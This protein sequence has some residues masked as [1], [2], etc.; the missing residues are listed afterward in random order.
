MS[1]KGVAG[2]VIIAFETEIS[3]AD[4]LVAKLSQKPMATAVSA[5]ATHM[6]AR[7]IE[8]PPLLW[9]KDEF[10]LVDQRHKTIVF[11]ETI[12]DLYSPARPQSGFLWPILWLEIKMMTDA[13]TSSASSSAS[14]AKDIVRLVPAYARPAFFDLLEQALRGRELL[15]H[16]RRRTA[17]NI[18]LKVVRHGWPT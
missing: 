14:I 10:I 11:I 8:V 4:W 18:W 1:Q 17:V 12:I 13:T 15:D 2:V 5:A 3:V 6:T 7:R 16:E 9:I